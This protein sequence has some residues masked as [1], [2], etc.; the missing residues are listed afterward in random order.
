MTPIAAPMR[1]H[2]VLIIMVGLVVSALAIL[3]THAPTTTATHNAPTTTTPTTPSTTS[4]TYTPTHTATRP[5]STCRAAAY[6]IYLSQ[7]YTGTDT[8]R[9]CF[10]MEDDPRVGLAL[11]YGMTPLQYEQAEDGDTSAYLP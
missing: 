7:D 1:I 4:P 5:E 8:E 11:D 3:T 10:G 2:H 6:R 9:A